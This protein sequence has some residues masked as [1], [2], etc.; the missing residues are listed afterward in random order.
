MNTRKTTL[1]LLAG[2]V[3][4]LAS[5]MA[6][7]ASCYNGYCENASSQVVGGGYNGTSTCY[8]WEGSA[9]RFGRICVIQGMIYTPFGDVAYTAYNST[10]LAHYQDP[11]LPGAAGQTIQCPANTVQIPAVDGYTADNG[12]TY[13]GPAT[14]C[15]KTDTY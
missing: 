13:A 14:L 11:N 7:W 6:A 2:A 10:S 5:P 3:L 9:T 15:V 12:T 4:A 1:T 8:A